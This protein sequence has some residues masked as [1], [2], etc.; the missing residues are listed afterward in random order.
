MR[1][2]QQDDRQSLQ[3]PILI[4]RLLGGDR[5]LLGK[6]ARRV[7]SVLLKGLGRRRITTFGEFALRWRIVIG[8]R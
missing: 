5:T 1:H 6:L 8:L 2:S 7:R 3:G 4:G